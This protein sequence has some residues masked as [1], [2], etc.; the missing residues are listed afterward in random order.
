MN[1]LIRII[2]QILSWNFHVANLNLPKASSR[3]TNRA[4]SRFAL[5]L[6][7]LPGLGKLRRI[8]GG[9][10]RWSTADA[11]TKAAAGEV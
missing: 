10:L 9:N 4:F 7:L 2:I 8:Q 5:S 6:S 3:E 1:F 11:T